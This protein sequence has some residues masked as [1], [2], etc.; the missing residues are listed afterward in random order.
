VGANTVTLTVTD[1]HGNVSSGTATVTV[2]DNIAPV[3]LTKNI[4]VY[5]SG[6]QATVTPNQVDNGSNDASGIKSLSLNK[7]SFDCSM[8]GANTVTLTVTDN[9]NNVSTGTAV[10]TVIG[11]TPTPAITVSRTDNTNTGLSANTIALGYGAQKLTLTASNANSPAGATTYA[12]SPATGLSNANIANPVFTPTQA[13]V[14]IFNVLVTSEYGCQATASVTVNVIDVRCGDGVKVAVYNATG[15][16][17]NPYVLQCVSPSAVPTKL[18]NGGTLS[19]GQTT[20]D[21]AAPAVTDVLA[22]S[23]LVV[24]AADPQITLKAYPN[25]FAQQTTVNFTVPVNDQKVSLDV[26]N[27]YGLLISHLYSGKAEAGHDYSFAFD[28]TRL[29]PGVYMVRLNTSKAVKNFRLIL[30]K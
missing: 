12:W 29:L 11:K 14:Y 23:E 19:E 28:G 3:V 6:G 16:S 10:V 1:T 4:T 5:L 15:S 24:K 22:P 7:T 26:Y 9:N 20:T 2:V 30:A 13:G 17:T 8:Q 18:A 21:I 27:I 25:P